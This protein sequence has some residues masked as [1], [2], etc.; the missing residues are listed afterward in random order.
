MV[1][2]GKVLLSTQAR[3]QRLQ[4]GDAVATQVQE[5]AGTLRLTWDAT[6][7]AFLTVTWVG[8]GG[9]RRTLAQDLRG[10]SA[11]LPTADLPAGGSFELIRSDGLN[12][13]RSVHGR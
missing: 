13:V 7:H 4:A 9:E 10:G 2:D 5:A 12:A 8:T 11:T 3:A 1:R 6:R